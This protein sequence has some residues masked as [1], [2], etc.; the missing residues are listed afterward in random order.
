MNNQKPIGDAFPRKKDQGAN[1]GA[2][3]AV[4]Q[5]LHSLVYSGKNPRSNLAFFHLAQNA[6]ISI[7]NWYNTF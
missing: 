1:L 4:P 7:S 2:V 5:K 3:L 6:C